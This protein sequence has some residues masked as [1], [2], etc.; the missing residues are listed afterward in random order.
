MYIGTTIVVYKGQEELLKYYTYY[1][2]ST[3]CSQIVRFMFLTLFWFYNST[4]S[5][6]PQILSIMITKFINIAVVIIGHKIDVDYMKQNSQNFGQLQ[7]VTFCVIPYTT[8]SNYV[9]HPIRHSP[10]HE[11]CIA[12]ITTFAPQQLPPSTL[13]GSDFF[14]MHFLFDSK[15]IHNIL[16]L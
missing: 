8:T 16:I 15:S 11:V 9:A 14:S 13:I 10:Q 1:N 7:K 5:N 3:F 12:H 6:H 4:T 2:T